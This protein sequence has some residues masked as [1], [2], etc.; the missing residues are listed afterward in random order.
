MAQLSRPYGVAVRDGVVYVMD[1]GNY[2]VRV[3]RAVGRPER[4]PCQSDFVR[5]A[6]MHGY[7][8]RLRDGSRSLMTSRQQT[9]HPRTRRHHLSRICVRGPSMDPTTGSTKEVSMSQ[10]VQRTTGSASQHSTI[11][12]RTAIAASCLVLASAL[13]V[14]PS[15]AAS[16]APFALPPTDCPGGAPPGVGAI[17]TIAGGGDILGDGG[18]ATAAVIDVTVGGL[19]VDDSGAVYFAGAYGD[20]VRRVGTDGSI[21]TLAGS[22]MVQPV[23]L[24]I[25]P[26]GTLVVADAR[27]GR[28]WRV[29]ADGTVSVVAG[30]GTGA[31]DGAGDA[32][33]ATAANVHPSHVKV[34]ADGSI[35][36]DDV[37]RYRVIG[38]DGIVHPFAGTSTAGFGGDGGPAIAALL[39]G[40][41]PNDRSYPDV[42]GTAVASDGSVYLTDNANSRIRKVDANGMITTVAGSGAGATQAMEVR[43]SRRASRTRSTWH[44]TTRATSTSRTTTTTSCA[45]SIS[46]GSSRT[47]AG[48]NRPY[49]GR[50]E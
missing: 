31:S 13:A 11:P 47:V 29:A 14:S 9:D 18:Q 35:Y 49:Q 28:I 20:S 15:A 37:P 25:A 39:G 33:P 5:P 8:I 30:P 4:Y 26:D 10:R 12:F 2:R 34:G 41:D 6:L 43:L 17:G 16:A 23:G 3:D 22:P 24:D 40:A 38:P 46:T 7:A 32:G 42:E 1:E 44:S 21:S 45:R 27:G 36:F 50:T 19:A 48:S